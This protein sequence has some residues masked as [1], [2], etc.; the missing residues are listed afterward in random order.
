MPISDLHAS[1][2]E[3]LLSRGTAG[4]LISQLVRQGLQALI[5]AE[6]ASALGAQGHVTECI[7]RFW[8]GSVLPSLLEPRRRLVRA[9]RALVMPE[10][11]GCQR[12]ISLIVGYS[13]RLCRPSRHLRYRVGMNSASR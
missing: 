13:I 7:P 2:L 1:G 3:H 11:P 5:E 4:E 8:T 6:A 9:P 12:A 10:G